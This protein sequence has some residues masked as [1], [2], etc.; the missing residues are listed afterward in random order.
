ML[1]SSDA[2]SEILGDFIQLSFALIS[3]A[4]P[5]VED[6]QSDY[7]DAVAQED[8]CQLDKVIFEVIAAA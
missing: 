3:K 8:D 7:L 6:D 4:V 1:S 2:I 5:I